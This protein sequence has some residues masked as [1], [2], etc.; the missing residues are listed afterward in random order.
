M[1]LWNRIF[2]GLWPKEKP[3]T[4]KKVGAFQTT[5]PCNRCGFAGYVRSNWLTG[6]MIDRTYSQDPCPHCGGHLEYEG[7]VIRLVVF[8][9][10]E[11]GYQR[12]DGEAFAGSAIRLNSEEKRTKGELR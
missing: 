12:Q 2:G 4:I 1:G 9:N 11:V 10:G 3:L 6:Q 5:C 7:L 8:S